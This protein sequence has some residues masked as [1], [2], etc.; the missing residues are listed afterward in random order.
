MLS[1]VIVVASLIADLAIG[2]AAY[3]M[4]KSNATTNASLLSLLAKHSEK[5]ENHESRIGVLEQKKAA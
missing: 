2:M 4:S 5:L 3:K 1:V